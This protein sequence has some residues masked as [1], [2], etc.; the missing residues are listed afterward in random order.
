LGHT[1]TRLADHK[2]FTRPRVQGDEY[3]IDVSVNVATYTTGGIVIP[4]SEL[5]LSKITSAY[6]IRIGG[7]L[8]THSINLVGG[9]DTTNNLYL[10]VNVEDGTTGIEA[11]LANANASLDGNPIIIRARGLI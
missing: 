2:G 1:T 4:A 3:V 8:A 10:E 11:E 6:I 5:G 9:A 7:G